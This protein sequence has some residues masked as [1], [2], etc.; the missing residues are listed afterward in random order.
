MESICKRLALILILIMTISGVGLLTVQP[1]CAQTAAPISS[2]PAPSISQLMVKFIPNFIN[3]TTTDPYTG[4]N[5]TT[6]QNLSTIV[7]DY[8]SE[9]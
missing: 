3:V 1:A 4:A 9:L 8:Q 6:T 5:T 7:I 2:V